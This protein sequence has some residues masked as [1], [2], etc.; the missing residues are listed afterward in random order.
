MLDS[1]RTLGILENH[2][3]DFTAEDHKKEP[4]GN[5]AGIGLRGKKYK[6]E[7]KRDLRIP[8]LPLD[9]HGPFLP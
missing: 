2:S 4:E 7:R 5:L 3:R 8:E 9:C 6:W 1:P